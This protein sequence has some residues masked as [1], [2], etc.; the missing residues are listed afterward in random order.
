M[1]KQRQTGRSEASP[2]GTFSPLTL[3]RPRPGGFSLPELLVCCALIALLALVSFRGLQGMLPAARVNRA[4]HEVV[5]LLEWA[6]WSAVRQGTVFRV[7]VHGEERRLTVLEETEDEEGGEQLLSVRELDLGREHP[8]VAF[9][10]ADDVKRT[11]GCEPVASSGI[12]LQDRMVRFLPS[13]TPDRSGSLYLIPEQ[14]IPDRKDR[15]RAISILLSTGRLQT[16]TFNPFEM[17]ECP[18]DGA[19][20]PL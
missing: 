19:W 7:L 6:R 15:M 8:A 14:D 3:P 12:H 17:S 10:T 20:Q 16:W 5:A 11:S 1:K 4:L 13:G 18:D 2:R 9:G